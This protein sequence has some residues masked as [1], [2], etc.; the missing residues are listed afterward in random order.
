MT[1]NPR[2]GGGWLAAIVL[3]VALGAVLSVVIYFF[4]LV[5]IWW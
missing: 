5:H 3:F 1:T 2:K 4:L